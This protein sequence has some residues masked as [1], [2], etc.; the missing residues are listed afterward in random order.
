[1]VKIFYW[2]LFS[3]IFYVYVGYPALLLFIR[4]LV[5][6]KAIKKKEYYPNVSLIMAV[7]NEG[8]IIRKR[9]ENILSLS[10]PEDNLEVLI[11][12]DASTDNTEAIIREYES[13]GIQLYR[14]NFRQG[15]TEAL[16]KAV[17]MATG[18]ILVFSDADVF[19][20]KNNIE[21]LIQ[22]FYDPQVGCVAGKKIPVSNEKSFTVSEGLYWEYEFSIKR[23]E[24]ELGNLVS[25]ACGLNLALRRK[26]YEP[27]EAMAED[28]LLPLVC[29][30]KGYRTVFEPGA[31]CYELLLPSA[32][33][34]F[35]RKIRI[36]M[37]GIDA[38]SYGRNIIK[39]L[40]LL[41][42]FQ[43]W[44]HKIMR[45]Y[46]SFGLVIFLI[47]NF[48]IKGNIYRYLLC[49]QVVFYSLAITG[50]L[51]ES[52]YFRMKLKSLR[53]FSIPYYFVNMNFAVILGILK[54]YFK[55]YRGWIGYEKIRISHSTSL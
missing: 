53:I 13:H 23:L 25:G 5:G 43:L 20:K 17:A 44:S 26:L 29:I 42:L 12:S 7:Y 41:D 21:M 50:A 46:I 48:F 39:S 36:V 16:N 1:M 37:G 9:I 51:L 14:Q 27:L 15:K 10:Y 30:H 40:G 11:V 24:S 54:Y 22:N 4:T 33:D 47:I 32:K 52:G 49:F 18:E 6:K 38:L 55:M 34:E 2:I 3:L 19:F 45:W 28:L 35:K 31:I 8:E